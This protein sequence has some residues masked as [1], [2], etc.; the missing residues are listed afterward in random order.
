[1]IWGER[2]RGTIPLKGQLPM[3]FKFGEGEY[4]QSTAF[5]HPNRFEWLESGGG[6][7]LCIGPSVNHIDI[8]LDLAQTWTADWVILYV[9]LAPRA[10][11]REAGRYQSPAPLDFESVHAFCDRFRS[12]LESDG[13]HHF[14]LASRNGG[15]LVYDNHQWIYAY[16]DLASYE[17][18]LRHHGLQPGKLSLPSPHSHHYHAEFDAEEDAL[19]SYWDWTH[20]P[21]RDGDR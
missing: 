8:M 6:V 15:T 3:L 4:R 18:V 13:R 21:L 9:L 12:F 5:C 19:M 2:A 10:G 20:S 1:M 17:T 11:N 7:R 14:W 16:G